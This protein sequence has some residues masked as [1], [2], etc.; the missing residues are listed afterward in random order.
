[1]LLLSFL[2]LLL[3]SCTLSLFFLH[4][5]TYFFLRKSQ[6]LARKQ[7]RSFS[8]ISL[9]RIFYN[10]RFPE[11][12]RGD[13][14]IIQNNYGFPFLTVKMI[15]SSLPSAVMLMTLLLLCATLL[16]LH[17]RQCVLSVSNVA[18]SHLCFLANK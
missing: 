11:T 2:V 4:C 1:M 18:L 13:T 17:S 9:V 6:E 8:R 5:P 12:L 10:P 16:V 15:L 14:F 3:L 7:D